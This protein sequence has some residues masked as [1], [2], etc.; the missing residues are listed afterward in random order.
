MIKRYK[1]DKND[2]QVESAIC[3]DAKNFYI[4]IIYKVV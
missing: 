4:V 3:K 2:S 1:Q